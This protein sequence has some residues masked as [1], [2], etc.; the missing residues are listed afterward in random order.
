MRANIPLTEIQDFE[1]WK[2]KEPLSSPDKVEKSIWVAAENGEVPKNAFGIDDDDGLGWP[3]YVGIV[4]GEDGTIPGMM[5]PGVGVVGVLLQHEGCNVRKAFFTGK[6]QY[7][8]LVGTKDNFTWVT[9][10]SGWTMPTNVVCGGVTSDGMNIFI[11]RCIVNEDVYLVGR[12]TDYAKSGLDLA[13]F[14][15]TA[16]TR[17]GCIGHFRFCLHD[18][19]GPWDSNEMFWALVNTAESGSCLI[20]KQPG[21]ENDAFL[22]SHTT[23][24]SRFVNAACESK[25]QSIEQFLSPLMEKQQSR[26]RLARGSNRAAS[27][28]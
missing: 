22:V 11:G 15:W 3:A 17:Q 5:L 13:P 27:T 2:L 20:L 1:S 16:G 12:V 4:Q 9:H 8:V 7:H 26:K 21:N 28:T 23:C 18:S 14:Y 10:K 25:N 6:T 19:L 24:T